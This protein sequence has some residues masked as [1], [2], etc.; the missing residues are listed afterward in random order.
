[1][2]YYIIIENDSGLTIAEVPAERTDEDVATEMG[3]VIVD[4]G[5]YASYEDAQD[6]MLALPD[7]DEEELLGE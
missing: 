6:A 5:P 1:M 2:P 4:P 3:G 7:D